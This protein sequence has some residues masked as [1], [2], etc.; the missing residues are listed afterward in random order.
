MNNTKKQVGI[1]FAILGVS[2][3]EISGGA[4]QYL[5]HHTA[6]H[7]VS[8]VSLWLFVGG[9]LCLLTALIQSSSR[10][11]VLGIWQQKRTRNR[12]LLFSLFG[13][14]PSQLSYFLSIS[15]GNVATAAALQF[16]SPTL[17]LIFMM[18]AW[19]HRPNRLE[20]L[21]IVISFSGTILLITNGNLSMFV[22]S[23]WAIFWGLMSGVGQVA[24]SLLPKP[25]LKE[26]PTS[27]VV[28]WGM[29]LG[30]LPLLP[31]RL[32]D[33]SFYQLTNWQWANV[34]FIV[35]VGTFVACLCYINSLKF[36]SATIAQILGSFELLTAALFSVLF[37]GQN[38]GLVEVLGIFL[39]VS[40]VL[41]QKPQRSA[42]IS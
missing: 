8:L 32:R 20:T 22:V 6:V 40:V 23:G 35:I 1:L 9:A 12:L 41:L 33:H 36:L 17:T 42:H 5:F 7:P 31:A 34:L 15:Y 13:F 25:L 24:Y 18:I 16:L 26:Y 39:I 2:C 4:S 30:S 28:G 11:L 21:A 38:L 29:L 3:W 14:L 27:V 37:L 10:Q 19:Y